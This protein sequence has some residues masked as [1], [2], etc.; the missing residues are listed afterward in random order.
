M[1]SDITR[2][3]QTECTSNYLSKSFGCHDLY[4]L[5]AEKINLWLFLAWDF[6]KVK[7]KCFDITFRE[8]NASVKL[9]MNPNFEVTLD[10]SADELH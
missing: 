5:C 7:S 2:Q 1:T 8:S 9:E 10:G 6:N 3:S 4:D